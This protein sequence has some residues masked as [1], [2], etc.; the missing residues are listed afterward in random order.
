MNSFPVGKTAEDGIGPSLKNKTF[1]EDVHL[2][3]QGT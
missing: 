2:K 3:M 1:I